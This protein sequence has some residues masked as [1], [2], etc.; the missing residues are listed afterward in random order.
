MKGKQLDLEEEIAKVTG[1]KMKPKSSALK[2]K[3]WDLLEFKRVLNESTPKKLLE[4]NKE[5]GNKFLPLKVIEQMLS[6]IYDAHEITI[7]FAPTVVE[8]QILTVVNLTVHHPVLKIALTYSGLSCVPIISMDKDFKWNHKNIPASKAYAIINAAK[9]IGNIF[10]TGDSEYKEVMK[11]YFEKKLDESIDVSDADKESIKRLKAMIPR[12]RTKES[13]LKVR[14]SVD[15][16]D[17]TEL[18]VA[19]N[20]KMKQLISK[21]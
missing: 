3:D 16:L 4:T 6:A 14:D 18:Y 21:K 7:P 10:R 11:P 19:Y 13:L 20:D 5:F 1:V 17:V 8:G 12:K 9:E 15:R 2:E